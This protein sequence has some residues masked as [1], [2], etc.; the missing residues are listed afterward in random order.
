MVPDVNAAVDGVVAPIEV[1]LIV[2]STT[3]TLDP[4]VPIVPS[5]VSA[6]IISI[7]FPASKTILVPA[8]NSAT[9]TPLA[10]KLEAVKVPPINTSLATLAPP[11]TI[12]APTPTP[13]EFVVE[14][15]STVC[16]EDAPVTT[17]SLK[18]P[19]PVTIGSVTVIVPFGVPSAS[20]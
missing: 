14:L 10:L 5:F 11:S 2:V 3:G 12:N 4:V 1:L 13:V 8:L 15:I 16:K 20:P 7:L 9:P 18:L 17:K 19:V 6:T